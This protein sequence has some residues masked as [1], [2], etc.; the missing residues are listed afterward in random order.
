VAS[1]RG[2]QPRYGYSPPPELTDGTVRRVPIVIVGA[3]PVGLAAAAEFATLGHHTLL[4]DD[5]DTVSAGSRAI[6]WSKRTLEI[7]DRIGVGDRMVA[8]GVVWNR[9]RL[10][11]R[12]REVYNFDLLPESGHQRPAFINLQQYYVE[13]YLVE[14]VLELGRTEIRWLNR[15]TAVEFLSDGGARVTVETPDGVYRVDADYVLAADGVRSTIRRSMGHDF[16]GKVFE[17]RFLI[18]DV[19]MKANFPSE[20]WFWFEPPFHS[21]QSVL[22]HRQPDDV[23]RIDFQLAPDADP[24]EERRPENVL[25]RLKQMLG[26][27]VEFSLEWVSVYTFTC[28]RM[29]RFRHGP[30]F[31]VGDSAHVVSPFGA[32]GGNGGIQDIDALCWKIALVLGDQAPLDLLD[33]Y[34]DER[35]PAA[36]ENIMNSARSTDFMTPKTP[37][38][39]DFREAALEMAT[40][41]PF[42]RRLVN[43][44]RLSVPHVYRETPLSMA[45][46]DVWSAGPVPGTPAPDARVAADT[47][48]PWLLRRL[49]GRFTLLRFVDTVPADGGGG[50]VEGLRPAVDVLT[51]ARHGQPNRSTVV[52]TEGL[53]FQRWSASDGSAYLVRPDQ[54]VAARWQHPS[55]HDISRALD[56]AVAR[57]AAVGHRRVAVGG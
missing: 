48:E 49:G 23:F 54:H 38:S 45:D 16:K 44:G 52:D 17:D 57:S 43:S 40:D 22:L 37:A 39:V 35:I 36:D 3:G 26:P 30:V 33:S 56:R 29:E 19:V 31:F 42:A 53:A 12:E 25:R 9:G 18:A 8:K 55:A 13:E 32:R 11:H 47:D 46:R 2:S 51:V 14:R 41:L 1:V 7:F 5:A 28:R 24:E 27:D 20:R 10:F 6:C 4:L 15:V 21:G 34:D 50:L